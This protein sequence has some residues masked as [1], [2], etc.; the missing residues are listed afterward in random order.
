MTVAELIE[1]LQ[2][3]NP[4]AP[5]RLAIQPS[6]P[7]EHEVGRVVEAYDQDPDLDDV[8]NVVSIGE[9]PQF[10]YLSG[11]PRDEVWS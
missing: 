2:S 11:W 3:M 4:E 6:W 5:V 9:G 8:T 1:Q 7:F 10:G